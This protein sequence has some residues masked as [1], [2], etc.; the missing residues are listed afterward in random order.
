[1]LSVLVLTI[2]ANSASLDDVINLSG[3][4]VNSDYS[5]ESVSDDT[6]RSIFATKKVSGMEM[7]ILNK[8]PKKPRKE[9]DISLKDVIS[10]IVSEQN[11]ENTAIHPMKIEANEEET[12]NSKI[13]SMIRMKV[14]NNSLNILSTL[15]RVLEINYKGITTKLKNEQLGTINSQKILYLTFDDGPLKGTVNVLKILEEEKVDA[16]MFCVG[17]HV[18]KKKGG[19][20]D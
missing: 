6:N 10:Q 17:K 14:T 15:D 18:V 2:Y 8:E 4:V 13:S 5:S 16:T 3:V 12:L 9:V 11:S 20:L 7:I 19:F 1:M